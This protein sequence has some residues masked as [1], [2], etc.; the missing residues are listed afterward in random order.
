[1]VPCESTRFRSRQPK[2]ILTQNEYKASNIVESIRVSV[3]ADNEAPLK[4]TGEPQSI[5]VLFT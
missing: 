5:I 4:N 2:M 3:V 1:M